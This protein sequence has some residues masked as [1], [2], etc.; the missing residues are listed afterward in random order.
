MSSTS[1]QDVAVKRSRVRK[2][3]S[4][5]QARSQ[6]ELIL[7]LASKLFWWKSSTEA[8]KNPMRFVAQV[9]TL[10]DWAEVRLVERYLGREA[11]LK[12]LQSPPPGVFDARSWA[13]WHA[14]F[15]KTPAPKLPRRNLR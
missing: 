7:D 13:Y 9:M 10:G 6:Q 2:N 15:R 5:C 1:N 11:F 3:V 12:V 4:N 14:V 8:L